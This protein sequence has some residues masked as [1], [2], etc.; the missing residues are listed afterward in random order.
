[1]TSSV[2][3]RRFR[4]CASRTNCLKSLARAVLRVD[5]V[6]VGDVVAVVLAR[7]RVEGQQPD[8]VDAE[9][10]DVVELADQPAKVAD[11]VVVAV[12]ERADVHFIHDGVLVPERI[13]CRDGGRLTH[14]A[15]EVVVEVAL[16]A[17]PAADAENVRRQRA[18]DRARRSCAHRAT[19]S[20]RR[21]ADRAPE[22]ISPP[23][24]RSRQ[25]RDRSS[26]TG[27]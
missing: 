25:G 9:I 1:M 16:G 21:T 8:G 12:E 23:R 10:L 15:S 7:R 6:I 11:A 2:M 19:G 14:S 3:T 4:R 27:A 24:G 22:T 17:H 13:L 20:G 26:R 5:V 18:A